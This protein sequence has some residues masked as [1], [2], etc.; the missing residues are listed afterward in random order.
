MPLA[1]GAH[2]EKASATGGARLGKPHQQ[3]DD[4]SFKFEA[5]AGL[6]T[7]NPGLGSSS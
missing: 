4:F 6:E 3:I 7:G 5:E 1:L 2:R